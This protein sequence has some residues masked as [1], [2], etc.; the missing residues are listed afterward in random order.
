MNIL[1]SIFKGLLIMVLFG[2]TQ[3]IFA[4]DNTFYMDGQIRTRWE[5]RD[6]ALFPKGDGVDPAMF[7][8]ERAR[9]SMGYINP[10]L[11]I[12]FSAQHVGVWGQDHMLDKNGRFILNEAWARFTPVKGL[13]FKLGRQALSYD[14][15]RILGGLDWH[16]A[17]RSFDAL[18]LEY[19]A[20]AHQI[21]GILAFNQNDEKVNG[22]FIYNNATTALFKSMQTLWYNY[23]APSTPF[24]ASLL[25]MNIG[26]DASDGIHSDSRYLQTF[27]PHITYGV[28][29]FS[30]VA[31]Y[32]MQT[33]KN[34]ADMSVMAHMA[35]LKAAYKISPKWQVF[36]QGDFLTGEKDGDDKFSA[37]DPL[38]GTHHKFY[39][40]MDY[41]YVTRTLIPVGLLDLQ[42]GTSVNCCKDFSLALH[43]HYFGSAVEIPGFD[44]YLGSEIDLQFNYK[45]MNHVTLVGGYST[46]FGTSTMDIVKGGNH[47][48]WQG[49]G[50]LQLNINPRLFS[51][52]W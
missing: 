38:Y 16:V 6:G 25:F 51:S 20:S 27:G 4:Q 23:K 21:H 49:W 37:F 32:Y 14:D 48:L 10:K 50:W 46:M 3:T 39:G 17:G 15:E 19:K 43:Y 33:G 36:A 31:T 2:V 30:L 26:L 44:K 45:I 35:S 1:N 18:K 12:K 34:L 5:Y 28:G 22:G 47:E 42:L 52:K 8:N 41:F 40:Y 24:S 9:I 29:N 7:I 11:E 13:S